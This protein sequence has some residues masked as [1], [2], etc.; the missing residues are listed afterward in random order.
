MNIAIIPARG[1]SKRILKKNIK[2][3]L[4]K[5]IIYYSIKIALESGLFDKVIV[6]T[7][8][9]EIKKVAE[10]FGAYVPFVRP[11]EL[12]DDITGTVAVINHA[13]QWCARNKH[14]PEYVCCI[15]ATSPLLQLDYLKM[16]YEALKSSDK[17]FAFSVTRFK[18]PI[19]RSLRIKNDSIEMFYPENYLTRS[20]DLEEGYHDAGQFYWGTA[21]AFLEQKN[22]F[23][24]RSVPIILPQYLVQDIDTQDD[25]DMAEF[26]YSALYK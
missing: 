15:Y 19:Q 13:V 24:D 12:S 8:D 9:H 11:D 6:S 16:G 17:L 3:F 21:D 20:Q 25:W 14:K 2:D 23:S 5:P 18:Y 26:M 10:N 22:I 4:G 1:G 7:D